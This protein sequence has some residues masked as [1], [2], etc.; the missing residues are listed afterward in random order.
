VELQEG[1]VQLGHHQVLVVAVVGDQRLAVGA[2]GKV[3]RHQRRGVGRP[4]PSGVAVLAGMADEEAG[5]VGREARVV[6]L[7]LL[8]RAHA[9][10]AVEVER[11]RA[12]L[13]DRRH[14]VDLRESGRFVA[15]DVV[16][17]ELA[18]VRD[19]GRDV[20]VAPRDPA[21]PR[22]ATDLPVEE[23][24]MASALSIVSA[25]SSGSSSSRSQR[26][27]LTPNRSATGGLPFRR[28]ISTAWISFLARERERTSCMRR[29]SRRR[30]TRV[31]SSGI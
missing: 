28:C 21:A 19:P 12:R 25:S 20:G 11:R 15:R 4:W 30:S 6:Q 16:V 29:A 31:R 22:R 7:G 18:E 1:D 9:V 26:R 2:A 3:V 13:L 27:P 17:D 8:Y 5:A 24:D 23:L 10:Q 14:V